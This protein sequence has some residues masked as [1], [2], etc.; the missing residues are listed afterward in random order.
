MTEHIKVDVAHRLVPIADSLVDRRI[1]AANAAAAS[2]SVPVVEPNHIRLFLV[3]Q[4]DDGVIA[5]RDDEGH[6]ILILEL[7]A[8]VEV[9]EAFDRCARFGLDALLWRHS[10]V[11]TAVAYDGDLHI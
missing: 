8:D 9:H 6:A 3:E 10:A 4:T 1:N 5:G 2:D 7:I 11:V